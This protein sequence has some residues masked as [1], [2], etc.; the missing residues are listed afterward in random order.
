MV[1]QIV[2]GILSL[3]ESTSSTDVDHLIDL[4]KEK[5]VIFNVISKYPE[6]SG[7]SK[8]GINWDGEVFYRQEFKYGSESLPNVEMMRLVEESM[9]TVF[10]INK[11]TPS[12]TN[13]LNKVAEH[14]KFQHEMQD[15]C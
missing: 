10:D 8:F 3:Q 4:Y 1:T 2:A 15:T 5:N 9:G 12:K 7:G 14:L 11:I 13:I 6:F